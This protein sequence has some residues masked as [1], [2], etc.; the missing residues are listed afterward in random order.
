MNKA[1]PVPTNR[2]PSTTETRSEL[3]SRIARLRA[4]AVSLDDPEAAAH[5]MDLILV[6]E[7]QLL[8]TP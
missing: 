2:P 3:E 1:S 7:V 6:L 8:E 5:Q 4:S